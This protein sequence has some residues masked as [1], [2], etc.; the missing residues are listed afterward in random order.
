MVWMSPSDTRRET[1][2]C[3]AVGDNC[4]AYF[5]RMELQVLDTALMSVWLRGGLTKAQFCASHRRARIRLRRKGYGRGCG[6]EG[7]ADRR[8]ERTA[9]DRGAGVAAG[10]S[11]LL[12]PRKWGVARW[13]SRS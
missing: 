1:S 12:T 2:G 10:L 9:V 3:P 4:T 13:L 8:G 6:V 11:V 5:F 7:G